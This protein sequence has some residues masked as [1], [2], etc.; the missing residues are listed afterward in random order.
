LRVS[1]VKHGR[2]A[3][4]AMLGVF[5]QAFVTREGPVANVLEFF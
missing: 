5:A 4:I 1:E 3:M 2:L